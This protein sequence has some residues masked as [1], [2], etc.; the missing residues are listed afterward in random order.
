MEIFGNTFAV[1]GLLGR[2]Q[3][4]IQPVLA[5]VLFQVLA[6]IEVLGC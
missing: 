4:G 3:H 5:G 2:R 1:A 6:N